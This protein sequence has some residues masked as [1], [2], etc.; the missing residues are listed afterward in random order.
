MKEKNSS[1]LLNA[2]SNELTLCIA[3]ECAERTTSISPP[4]SSRAVFTRLSLVTFAFCPVSTQAASFFQ[5]FVFTFVT[6]FCLLIEK[7]L[8]KLKFQECSTRTFLGAMLHVC[9]P[10]PYLKIPHFKSCSRK[11]KKREPSCRHLAALSTLMCLSFFF[12]RLVALHACNETTT[13]PTLHSKKK[14]KN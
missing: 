10:Y 12:F 13:M 9:A 11:R 1:F 8:T 2:L 5:Q 4:F 7:F 3:I 14:K 6:A